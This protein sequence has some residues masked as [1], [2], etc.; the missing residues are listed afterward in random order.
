MNLT[1]WIKRLFGDTPTDIAE[2]QL[3]QWQ[4]WTVPINTENSTGEDCYYHDDFDAIREEVSKIGNINS[5]KIIQ[6]SEQLI[7]RE[8]KDLRLS[9]YYTYAKLLQNGLS[10][11]ADGLEL[12]CSLIKVFGKGLHPSKP[13]Q[14]KQILDW[15]CSERVL[16]V[17]NKTDTGNRQDLERTLSVLVLLQNLVS[18]WEEAYRPNFIPLFNL[19]EQILDEQTL[20]VSVVDQKPESVATSNVPVTEQLSIAMATTGISSDKDLLDYTRQAANYLRQQQ[21]YD[22]AFHLI[23]AIRWDSLSQLPP[24]DQELRTKLPSPRTELKQT[25]KRLVHQKEWTELQS[26]VEMAFVEGANHF[27]LDLQYYAWQAQ[28]GKNGQ[29]DDLTRLLNQ[30][31]EL[32]TLKFD[33][34]TPFADGETQNWLNTYVVYR[35]STHI[36]TPAYAPPSENWQEAEQQ[37]ESIA[38]ENGLNAALAWLQ[39]LPQSPMQGKLFHSNKLLLMAALCERH[40]QPEWALHLYQQVVTDMEQS[41]M[42]EWEP[43]WSFQAYA[44]LYRVLSVRKDLHSDHA[45]IIAQLQKKL[46]MLDPSAAF[47]LFSGSRS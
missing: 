25:L 17:L 39:N 34:G 37:A 31:P 45:L 30:F 28:Q 18:T 9:V 26:R 24:Y 19:F 46:T 2:N 14:R 3:K 23:R 36:V 38:E 5:D 22:A 41:N 6:L 10:G 21:R 1:K 47:P 13:L 8:S 27:W 15:L 16:D 32:S 7:K 20:Q 12:S 33:D 4:D 11:F 35:E 44:H 29:L 43:M 42:V 40:N